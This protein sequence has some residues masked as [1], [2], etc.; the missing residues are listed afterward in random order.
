MTDDLNDLKQVDKFPFGKNRYKRLAPDKVK[1]INEIKIKTDEYF[2]NLS[3]AAYKCL[4]CEEFKEYKKMFFELERVIN[5]LRIEYPIKDC[6]EYA[7]FSAYCDAQL[8]ILYQ[9]ITIPEEL[10]IKAEVNDDKKS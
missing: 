7:F 9:I 6:S 3:E 10:K 4:E 5:K 2:T 1:E 8:K